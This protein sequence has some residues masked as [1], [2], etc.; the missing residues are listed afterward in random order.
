MKEAVEVGLKIPATAGKATGTERQLK[1]I[2][3]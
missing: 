3:L 1:N 2:R